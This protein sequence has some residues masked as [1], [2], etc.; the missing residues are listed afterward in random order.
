MGHEETGPAA[1]EG[2]RQE[3]RGEEGAG[4]AGHAGWQE[5]CHGDG[6]VRDGSGRRSAKTC[7]P[8]SQA[9]LGCSLQNRPE[10]AGQK[11]G[12]QRGGGHGNDLLVLFP[13]V[14]PA[15]SVLPGTEQALSKSVLN[16]V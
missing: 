2:R 1:V 15:H 4:Q 13:T 5:G 7:L 11:Q 16:A 10:G 3:A 6:G 9:R 8:C 12:D 14:P